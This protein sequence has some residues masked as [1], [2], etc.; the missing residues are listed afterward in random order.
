MFSLNNLARKGLSLAKPDFDPSNQLYKIAREV[1]LH[2]S[3]LHKKEK[4]CNYDVIEFHSAAN[5]L[6]INFTCCLVT[7]AY[8]QP[9]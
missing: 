3:P 1:F 9:H 8:P 6:D 5:F 7:M 2:R 4:H